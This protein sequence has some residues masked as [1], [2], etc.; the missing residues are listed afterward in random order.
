MLCIQ[1]NLDATYALVIER[2]QLAIRA[3]I[4]GTLVVVAMIVCACVYLQKEH[5][6]HEEQQK[7][8]KKAA[9]RAKAADN[10]KSVFLFNM[11]HDI[12]TPMNAII[13]YIDLARRHIDEPDKLNTYMDNIQDCGKKLLALLDNVLDLARIESNKISI[14]ESAI[15]VEN[16]FASCVSMF[17]NSAEEKESNIKTRIKTKTQLCLFR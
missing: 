15:N 8:L 6:K 16:T 12:R 1:L 13:G 4:L 5:A 11:S 14:E 9:E 17:M 3:I 2:D 7:M 10:S